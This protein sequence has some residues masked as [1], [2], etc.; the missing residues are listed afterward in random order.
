MG[1]SGYKADSSVI[2]ANEIYENNYLQAPEQ[3]IL[4]EASGMKIGATANIVI[5]SNY[6]HHN[7]AKGIWVDHS[8]PTTV[9]EYNTVTDNSLEG[10][11]FESSYTA[12]IRY[13]T[14]DRNGSYNASG[15][16]LGRAGIQVNNS[17]DV[18]I[19]N[20]TVRDNV[21]G[22]SAMQSVNSVIGLLGPLRIANLYV[23]DNVIRMSIGRTGVG[24]STGETQ[25]YTT[26]N[27]R[28]EHNTYYL[29]PNATYFAWN[30]NYNVDQN[31]WRGYGLD[32]TGTFTRF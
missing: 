1:I 18:E 4:S 22:I 10:I 26:W 21:N 31:L 9:I 29:G 8:L 14:A 17:P 28:F 32:M 16:W 23:H 13:N 7:L 12:K 20:N 11:K 2:E 24:Q 25:V 5:R 27:N 6:V 30:D 15:T 19:Y 3:P